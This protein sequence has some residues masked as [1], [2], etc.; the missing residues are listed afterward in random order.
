V[1]YRVLN[2]KSPHGELPNS[3]VLL[4]VELAKLPKENDGTAAWIWLRL[5]GVK[6]REELEAFMKCPAMTEVATKVLEMSADKRTRL[7]AIS[8]EK[9]RHD[10]EA[11]LH[12]ADTAHERGMAE[13]MAKGE[14]KGHADVTR[15]LLKRK[16]PLADILTKRPACPM[17]K[18]LAGKK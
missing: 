18:H 7:R 2:V 15:R 8:R 4:F 9:W 12:D 13:G 17:R 5:F 10:Q 11:I 6:T 16:M 3:Q 1:V 14:V